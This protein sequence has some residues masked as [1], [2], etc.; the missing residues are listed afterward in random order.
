MTET[1]QWLNQVLAQG[2][3]KGTNQALIG[4]EQSQADVELDRL[5]A[6]GAPP[7]ATSD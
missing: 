6:M 3:L 4:Q 5:K 7:E 1:K 2:E